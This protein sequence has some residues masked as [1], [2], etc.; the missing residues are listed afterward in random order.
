MPDQPTTPLQL[1]LEQMLE[2]YRRRVTAAV[3]TAVE[4]L[5]WDAA[6]ADATTTAVQAQAD[7]DVAAL[8]RQLDYAT[9]P[10]TDL[11]H[12][13]RDETEPPAN[14][15]T[16]PHVEEVL[17]GDAAGDAVVDDRGAR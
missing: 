3:G 4:P 8:A 12:D 5:I 6:I 7:R 16:E 15:D 10:P 13:D 9:A 17:D 2:I 11:D 14:L 1:P